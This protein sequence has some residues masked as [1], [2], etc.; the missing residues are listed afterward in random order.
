VAAEG[1][2]R[3]EDADGF[4]AAWARARARWAETILTARALDEQLLDERVDG[5]WSLV[6]TLRHLVF[7]TDSWVSRGILG[8]RAPWHPLGIPPTGMTRVRGLPDQEARPSLDE[9][10]ALRA[11]R[12]ATVHRVVT[13]VT[14]AE[15]D[16]ER[17][18]IGAGHPKAG[19]WPVRRC[20]TAVLNEEW[21]HR[22]YAERDLA[23]LA[24]RG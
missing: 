5:E 8:E 22:D 3:P 15:L 17:R 14:D 13:E 10:L 1:R 16:E 11:G 2:P 6:E 18:S 20:L 7:V 23:E 21:R 12:V 19:L 4:R 9:V 24:A